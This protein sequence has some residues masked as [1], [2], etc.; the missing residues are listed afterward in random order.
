M[1][2]SNSQSSNNTPNESENLQLDL[3]PWQ[4]TRLDFVLKSVLSSKSETT[5]Q[6]ATK[7]CKVCKETKHVDEFPRNGTWYRPE[8]RVCNNEHQRNYHKLRRKQAKPPLG[9]PCECCGITDQT[10]CWDHCHN[11]SEHR[12]WLCSNCNTGIGKLG[13][14]IEGVLKALDYLGNVHNLGLN[15]ETNDD[16]ATA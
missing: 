4:E 8:C 6:T 14:D 2:K 5:G 10:L 11:S 13:D 3:L 15:Q 16:L 1:T 7:T 12:G 9:T